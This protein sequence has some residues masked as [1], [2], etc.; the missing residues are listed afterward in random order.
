VSELPK[1]AVSF[2]RRT[3]LLRWT[4]RGL[5]TMADVAELARAMYEATKHLGPPPQR[6][7]GLCDSRDFPVQ[8]N[9]VSNALGEID[10]AGGRMR[11][12]RFAIVVGSRM[13]KLQ[14]ERTLTGGGVRVFMAMDE[15]EAWLADKAG[16]A[17]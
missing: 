8:T 9:A 11:R 1:F 15:A 4:M 5:W 6:Y 7:D 3:R 10:R 16:D 12:G 17:G 13:N 2:D 14:A